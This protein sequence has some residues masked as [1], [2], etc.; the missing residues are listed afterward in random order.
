[1]NEIRSL[2]DYI[3]EMESG[4]LTKA[5]ELFFEAA[6]IGSECIIGDG[7]IPPF[8][9][10]G[11]PEYDRTI[12]ISLLCYLIKGGCEAFHTNK[13][14]LAIQGAAIWGD[15]GWSDLT[16]NTSVSVK[17]CLFNYGILIDRA[18]FHDL[19]IVGCTIPG[20]IVWKSCFDDLCLSNCTF[21]GVVSLKGSEI[22]GNFILNGTS[23]N[24][25]KSEDSSKIGLSIDGCEIGGGFY[26]R[27]LTS[28]STIFCNHMDVRGIISLDGV[29]VE[30]PKNVEVSHELCSMRFRECITGGDFSVS[31]GGYFPH[32]IDLGRISIGG[33]CRFGG[34]FGSIGSYAAVD[35]TRASIEKDLML[36]G[37]VYRS[38]INLI[39]SN[40]KG[41]VYIEVSTLEASKSALNMQACKIGTDLFFRSIR[42]VKGAVCLRGASIGSFYDDP[43]SWTNDELDLVDFSYQRLR[44][45][46]V[47]LVDRIEWLKRG[48]VE[49]PTSTPRVRYFEP[50]TMRQYAR[51]LADTGMHHEARAVMFEC[52]RFL[53]R[54]QRLFNFEVA[55][56][57]SF[58]DRFSAWRSRIW[59]WG[60]AVVLQF[61]I[62]FGY[63]IHRSLYWL[64][65]LVFVSSAFSHMAWKNGDFAPNSGPILVSDEWREI[66]EIS[67]KPALV[68][69][70]CLHSCAEDGRAGRDW[71]T[72]HP[73][74]YAV[75][76]AVPL[77]SLGQTDAWAPS[78]TRGRWGKF[79]YWWR[80][81]AVTLGWIITALAAAGLGGF[82]N[83]KN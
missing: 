51:L 35:L 16:A 37:S 50:S 80:W 36:S 3:S 15:M 69:S 20:I 59:S 23:I 65:A 24:V 38:S 74:A 12:R 70:E 39:S 47:S 83:R 22:L 49:G 43:S 10:D 33:I 79:L 19:Q 17:N 28:R 55:N 34:E 25:K 9:E 41:S 40:I 73:I 81:F 78:T 26:A 82:V 21:D 4:L 63:K 57:D 30:P 76:L 67:S 58:C 13:T 60:K 46:S 56:R 64:A 6:R 52:E 1:M 71:E 29:R 18:E 75:D 77:F 7:E 62:G 45:P 72:F 14:I 11:A 32:G 42:S 54:T 61:S 48:S 31:D 8:A 53:R 2:A 27:G 66:S 44:S 5:E 68:W